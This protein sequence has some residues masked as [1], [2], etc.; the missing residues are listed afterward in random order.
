MSIS[1][2]VEEKL[3]GLVI[4]QHHGDR[5][6]RVSFPTQHICRLLGESVGRH[7]ARLHMAAQVASRNWANRKLL[8]F[9]L[10]FFF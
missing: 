3:W 2:M 5:S 10:V 8:F 4:L 1:I 9:S 6:H 7:I